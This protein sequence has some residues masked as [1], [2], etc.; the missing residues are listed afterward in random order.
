MMIQNKK[1]KFDESA[2]TIIEFAIV[3]PVVL[4]FLM[5]VLEFGLIMLSQIVLDNAAVE[6]SRKGATG[7]YYGKDVG[8]LGYTR[9]QFIKDIVADNLKTL[10]MYSPTPTPIVPTCELLSGGGC[11]GRDSD[12]LVVYTITYNWKIFTPTLYIIGTG[13]YFPISAKAVVK[14]E[15]F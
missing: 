12:Q 14:N 15:N 7:S 9:S 4:F 6:V 1:L 11:T 8:K 3:F 13:G 5:T 10:P 2:A